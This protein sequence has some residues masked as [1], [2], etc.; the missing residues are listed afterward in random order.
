ML[1]KLAHIKKKKSIESDHKIT[2]ILQL[3][4]MK[5]KHLL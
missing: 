4:Q 3:V 5:F 2:Q 1:L